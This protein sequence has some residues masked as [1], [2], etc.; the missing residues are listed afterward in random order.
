M[1]IERN[2]DK[3]DANYDEKPSLD[4]VNENLVNIDKYIENSVRKSLKNQKNIKG[5]IDECVKNYS[6]KSI[7]TYFD[8]NSDTFIDK[9]I[10]IS[11][12]HD[13]K[14]RY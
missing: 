10:K 8:N 13:D 11:L 1:D 7:D 9:N 4:I 2:I 6:K 5:N 12:K 14:C 3:S